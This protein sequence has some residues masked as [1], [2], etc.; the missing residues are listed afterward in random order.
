MKIPMVTRMLAFTTAALMQ[1]ATS[2]TSIYE[3]AVWLPSDNDL[4]EH[5]R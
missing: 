5:G 4:K 3:C 2:R 1:P